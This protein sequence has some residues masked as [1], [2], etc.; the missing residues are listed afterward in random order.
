[1]PREIVAT[2]RGGGCADARAVEARGEAMV[3][4]K[5]AAPKANHHNGAACGARIS[6]DS[7]CSSPPNGAK[8]RGN[9]PP[10][11]T[12]K[13]PSSRVLKSSF[14]RTSLRVAFA[15]IGLFLQFG[16]GFAA[17]VLTDISSVF[18]SGL[19]LVPT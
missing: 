12:L 16:F 7:S 10:F 19:F 5:A 3:A 6:T 18:L 4:S 11:T 8:P 2:Q 15:I 1:M 9:L 17:T 14:F 13:C